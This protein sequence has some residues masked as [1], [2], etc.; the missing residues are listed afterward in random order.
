M[1]KPLYIV[2]GE[3][4]RLYPA[5]SLSS[6]IDILKDVGVP[7]TWTVI[8][9][10]GH[11][12]EWLP[13]YLDEVEKFKSSNRRDP[14]P[15]AIQWVADRTDRYNRNHWI[16]IDG[17]DGDERPALLQVDRSSNLISVEARGIE[18][19]RLLLSPD[20][21]D[22]AR[23]VEVVVNGES[24]FYDTVEQSAE[25]LLR[26][27]SRDLDRSMLITAELSISLTD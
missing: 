26:L 23:P 15:S 7:H 27:A 5:A 4:D 2:N 11:N 10:G 17:I 1:N 13:D 20:F 8:A 21:I 22:F 3:N 19:F 25:S 14:F 12:T 16:Q 24:Q 18:Q 6:F 9:E